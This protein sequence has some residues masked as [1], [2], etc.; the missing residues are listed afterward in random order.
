MTA[1]NISPRSTHLTLI[2]LSC[3]PRSIRLQKRSFLTF[4]HKDSIITP[5]QPVKT[6]RTNRSANLKQHCKLSLSHLAKYW[7]AP[8]RNGGIFHSATLEILFLMIVD[9][10]KHSTTHGGIAPQYTKSSHRQSST[11][12]LSTAREGKSVKTKSPIET[13]VCQQVSRPGSSNR[14]L[15]TPTLDGRCQ[16]SIQLD[17]TLCNFIHKVSLGGIKHKN[18]TSSRVSNPAPTNQS[19]LAAR[20]L[21]GPV[22]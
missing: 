7:K 10:A 4:G 21:T 22:T 17:Y 19:T 20:V 18:P 11:P 15:N 5:F 1:S 16:A 3:L 9:T 6:N 13:S 2:S 8:V 14:F 12:S